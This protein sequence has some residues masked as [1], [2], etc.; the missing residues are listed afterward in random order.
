VA[1]L[2]AQAGWWVDAVTGAQV[3]QIGGASE[4]GG[5]LID[6]D[7]AAGQQPVGQTGRTLVMSEEFNGTMAVDDTDLGLVH[8]RDGGAQ[9]ATWYP[10]WPRFNEQDPG[11]NHTNTN[12]ASY[13]T[14]SQVSLAD[15]ACVLTS[16]KQETVAGLP[17]TSG[18]ITSMPSF[19]PQY[20]YTEAR[21]KFSAMNTGMWGGG[22]MSCSDFND[23]P[24]EI[25]YFEYFAGDPGYGNNVWMPDADPGYHNL[26]AH[27]IDALNWHVYGCDWQPSGVTFYLDGE[28]TSTTTKSPGTEQYL[29]F[30]M[31][32]TA[33]ANPSYATA[34]LLIDYVRHWQ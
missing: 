2:I 33:A 17:Y 27:A 7:T 32:N 28:Q 16:V 10:D 5:A 6:P 20:G 19:T 34:A 22:W 14:T 3:R 30:D 1:V 13:F 11:G 24:P 15:G 25:D 9:W 23:W 8:F 29:I 31:G 21:L 26:N 4:P 12:D 18:M